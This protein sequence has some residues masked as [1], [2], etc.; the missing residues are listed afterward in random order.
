MTKNNKSI[1]RNTKQLQSVMYAANRIVNLTDENNINVLSISS[2]IKDKNT[3]TNIISDI[4]SQIIKLDKKVAFI[5]ISFS[6]EETKESNIDSSDSLYKKT[7]VNPE[8]K[9][10]SLLID[11]LKNKYDIVIVNIP[12]VRIFA[13]ALQYAKIC[14]NIILIERY[15]YSKHKNFQETLDL[16][17]QNNVDIK[18]IITYK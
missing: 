11:E 9:K 15:L 16:L 3:E 8:T 13:N 6:G 17:K 5:D 14:G 10:L 4:V 7:I 2:S 18:G 12:P 1:D